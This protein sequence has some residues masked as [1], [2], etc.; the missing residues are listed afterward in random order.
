MLG[1]FVFLKYWFVG[2]PVFDQLIH[3]LYLTKLPGIKEGISGTSIF[4]NNIGIIRNITD[5]KREASL[6]VLKYFIIKEKLKESFKNRL[7]GIAVD[8]LLD[9]EELCKDGICDIFKNAQFTVGPQNLRYKPENYR[10]RYQKYIYQYLFNEN[11]TLE[12]TLKHI[13]D[14]TKVYYV[15]LRT[16]DSY[17]GLIFVIYTL[18]ISVLMLL[19]LIVL[20]KDNFH[21]FFTFLSDDFW[22]ITVLGSILILW[23][24]YISFGEVQSIKCHLRPLYYTIGFTLS[25]CPTIH[26]LVTLFPEENKIIRCIVKHKYLFL[27][28]NIIIDI[29]LC[30]ISLL[31]PYTS[32][33]ILVENGESFEKC[34][35]NGIYSIIILI[36]YKL[37][38]VLLM[39][40]LIFVEWNISTIIYDIKF[41]VVAL[42]VDILFI[43]LIFVFYFINIKNYKIYFI[44]QT[45]TTYTISMVNYV[46]LYGYRVFLGFIRKR[47]IKLQFIN[48]INEKFINTE[49]QLKTKTFDNNAF[50]DSTDKENKNY[51]SISESD[52]KSKF[53]KRMINYHYTI[54]YSNEC[55]TNTDVISTST[56]SN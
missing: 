33:Y 46:F 5:D 3:W 6:E 22:I 23:I 44:L 45:V 20:F 48:N 52:N 2:N 27:I 16:E 56:T 10:K 40:F 13:N 37:L 21:P 31:N 41:I 47:D 14:I 8:E 1:Q 36:V 55:S 18:V 42:Y 53:L 11:K 19:S 32:Q 4:G 29:L 51:T 9:E 35:F 24:P 54:Y 17:V 15:S 43:I 7:G 49:S 26:K 38:I 30:S 50:C 39:L 34:K 28:F 12:E 25:V